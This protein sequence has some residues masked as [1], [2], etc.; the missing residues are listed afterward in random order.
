MAQFWQPNHNLSYER[1]TT[2]DTSHLL[3]YNP[4]RHLPLASQRRELPIFGARNQ[5]LYAVEKYRT[6]ILVGETGKKIILL[7]L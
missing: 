4:N 7:A 2:G 5:I 6:V 3:I 1:G